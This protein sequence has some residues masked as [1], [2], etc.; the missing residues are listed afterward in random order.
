MRAKCEGGQD[1]EA[2]GLKEAPPHYH[3]HRERLRARFL[4]GGAR[5]LADYELLELVLFRALHQRDV[6]PLAKTLL[7]KFGSF[8]EVICASRARLEEVDGIGPAV[9]TEIKIIEAAAKELARGEVRAR[10]VLS[11]WNAVLDY[12]RSAMAFADKEELRVLYLDKRNGLIAD[13]VQQTG[14]V[15]HTPVYPREIVKRALELS[16]TAIILVHNHPSGD[17]TP[18]RA[19]IAMTRQVVEVAGA[20]GL[21]LHDHIIIGRDGHVSFKTLG[22][23]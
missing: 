13:E 15:D 1:G 18:S 21:T 16:A 4:E 20:L 6:K 14:T 10:P 19:D 23:L 3:G 9:I 22:L 12:C 11:S 8:A 17:P 5:A 7:A 2:R